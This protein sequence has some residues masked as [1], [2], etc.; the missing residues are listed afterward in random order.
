MVQ[1]S[2]AYMCVREEAAWVGRKALPVSC[3]PRCVG[4]W[5]L[6]LWVNMALWR[7]ASRTLHRLKVLWKRV[8]WA[9]QFNLHCFGHL[10]SKS[11]ATS[12]LTPS[13]NWEWKKLEVGWV[14]FWHAPT[15][16]GWVGLCFHQNKAHGLH[17]KVVR[18][19]ENGKWFS[20][21][22]TSWST[23]QGLT[24]HTRFSAQQVPFLWGPKSPAE[25]RGPYQE[26]AVGERWKVS[27]TASVS[28][29]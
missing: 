24:A 3:R 15:P 1:F 22:S 19:D 25:Q 26:L 28:V 9:C 20:V 5:L 7:D 13:S 23:L 16:W 14:T 8:W 4:S 10:L 2:A 12:K 21:V 6:Y 29:I 11:P 17:I 18:V 27:P